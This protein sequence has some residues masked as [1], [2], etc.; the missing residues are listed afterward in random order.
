VISNG[1]I[2]L[3]EISKSVS[4]GNYLTVAF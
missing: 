4:Q 2:R 1:H 3:L